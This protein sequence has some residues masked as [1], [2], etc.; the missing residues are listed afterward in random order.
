MFSRISKCT[1]SGMQRV[2]AGHDHLRGRCRQ[3]DGFSLIELLVVILIIGILAAIA[4]PAFAGQKSKASDAQ[5]KELVRTAEIT[6]RDDL[7]RQQ[8]RI[9]E[10][11]RGRTEPLRTVDPL[12]HEH[13]PGLPERSNRRQRRIHAHRHRARRRRIHDQQEL[14]RRGD[15]QVLEPDHENR[16]RGRRN[17]ELVMRRRSLAT[18]VC[19]AAQRACTRRSSFQ[20][21]RARLAHYCRGVYDPNP[22]QHCGARREHATGRPSADA[23]RHRRGGQSR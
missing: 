5:A 22:D 15:P 4:I 19:W 11:Q 9:L 3:E 13:E 23:R 12:R 8:R 10:G 18:A 14:E 17:G 6:G 20:L 2:Q 1:S 16:M 7:R 21:A